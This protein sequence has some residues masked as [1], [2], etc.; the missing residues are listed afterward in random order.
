MSIG[1]I[2]IWAVPPTR[3]STLPQPTTRYVVSTSEM[4]RGGGLLVNLECGHRHID[5]RAETRP[6]D[7]VRCGRCDLQGDGPTGG[8]AA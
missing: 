5:D 6:G 4:P 7:R 1:R 8:R 2:A 3:P